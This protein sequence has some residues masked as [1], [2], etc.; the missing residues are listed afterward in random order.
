MSEK[1]KS[2]HL[3]AVCDVR[4]RR[5]DTALRLGKVGEA[6]FADGTDPWE[7][8][9]LGCGIVL[10]EAHMSSDWKTATCSNCYSENLSIS[11]ARLTFYNWGEHN[12]GDR[13]L[14]ERYEAARTILGE[15][16]TLQ[17]TATKRAEGEPKA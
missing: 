2:K 12:G 9:C 17:S 1:I 7:F 5:H 15:A 16:R 3:I 11:K 8:T 10:P 13:E 6:I 14:M 4:I